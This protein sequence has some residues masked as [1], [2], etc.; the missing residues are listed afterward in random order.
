MVIANR[1]K[2]MI[3]ALV[4]AALVA[5]VS[6]MATALT[7]AAYVVKGNSHANVAAVQTRLS[8]LGYY[9][10]TVDGAWG[11]RTSAAVKKFQTP[12]G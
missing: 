2:L 9:T 5:A 12:T 4:A 1:K 6:L 7:S 10:S 3:P 8:T 11:S